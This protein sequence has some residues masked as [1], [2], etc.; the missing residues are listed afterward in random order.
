M[1]QILE[2]AAPSIILYSATLIASNSWIILL[3]YYLRPFSLI[4]PYQSIID[5]LITCHGCHMVTRL[6]DISWLF[7]PYFSLLF[8]NSQLNSD[9][10][11]H[12]VFI[13]Q[14]SL[15]SI[16]SHFW[17]LFP[18]QLWYQ[19]SLCSHS[20]VHFIAQKLSELCHHRR[21]QVAI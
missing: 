12:C 1:A 9:L 8:F 7:N 18:L 5:C 6:Y 2:Q 15:R 17:L 20:S 16:S 10:I 21:H 3:S 11:P 13:H 14:S 19:S 4:K